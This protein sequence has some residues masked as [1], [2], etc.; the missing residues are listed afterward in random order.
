MDWGGD[1]LNVY[2]N[3]NIFYFD[4]KTGERVN[5]LSFFPSGTITIAL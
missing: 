2:D 3:K 4:R 1:V 5:M